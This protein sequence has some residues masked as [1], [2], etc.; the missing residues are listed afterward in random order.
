MK[1]LIALISLVFASIL[2]STVRQVQA[3]DDH[4]NVALI[5]FV[6]HPSLDQIAAGVYE[7]LEAQGYIEG[8]NLTVDFHN[9]EGDMNLLTSI[10]DQV[11]ANKPDII[12]PITTPVAQAMQN[13]TSDL[14]IVFAGVTDPV[15]AGL[16]TDLDQPDGNITGT[17]D[18]VDLKGHF[19]LMLQI[20]PDIKK[21]GM[22]YSTNEDSALAEI[23]EAKALVEENYGIEVVIEG[24]ASAMDMQLVAEKL[25]G[26]VD[27]IYV[28]SDNLIASS[29]ATLL[30]ATDA[31]GIAVYP[32]VD[33]MVRQGGVA[34]LAID[35]ADLGRQ[36]VRMA[37]AIHDGQAI[38]DTPVESVD[39][40]YQMIN[41][42]AADRL[43]IDLP[44]ELLEA[45]DTLVI[46]A[47]EQ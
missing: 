15:D 43:G 46:E 27:A 25:A 13:T 29:F 37:L 44:A 17:T 32:S 41:P 11:L 9:V 22:L 12:I 38:A 24:I 7:E 36:A 39:N 1:K 33:M 19:D 18:V 6:S 28:P 26:E 42:I 3:Q 21:L 35:Q 5:Q 23:E 20:Q 31:A 45:E 2:P 4:L 8:E 47:E 40:V 10:G 34:A 14:P 16:V 30:D